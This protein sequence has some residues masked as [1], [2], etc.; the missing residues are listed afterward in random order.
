MPICVSFWDTAI[1]VG[2]NNYHL[3]RTEL[4]DALHH[5][6]CIV[7][8]KAWCWA[9]LTS[10]NG[11]RPTVDNTWRRTPDV[12]LREFSVLTVWTKS[13]REVPLLFEDTVV[14]LK[15]CRISWG[16]HVCKNQLDPCMRPFPYNTGLW[17]THRHRAG[18]I[19][20]LTKRCTEKH[21]MFLQSIVPRLW[22]QHFAQV[23]T[24]FPLGVSVTLHVCLHVDLS[25]NIAQQEDL[26]MQRYCTT[27]HKYEMS[28]LKRLAIG[29]LPSRTLKVIRSITS[30]WG[31]FS[32]CCNSSI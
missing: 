13:E 11:R 28:H 21:E 25:E 6:H 3:T 24:S 7:V 27:R 10:D 31:L 16:K 15:H 8:H 22:W 29:E 4:H 9:W 19:T 23:I 1:I 20:A 12:P 5:D 30:S 26:H 2:Q 14:S 17:Q 18:D 32:C